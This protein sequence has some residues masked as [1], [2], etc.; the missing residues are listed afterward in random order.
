[1]EQEEKCSYCGAEQEI[2]KLEID[3]IFPRSLGGGNEIE[4]LTL[5]CRK[6]NIWKTNKLVEFFLK[7]LGITEYQKTNDEVINLLLKKRSL[8]ISK[9]KQLSVRLSDEIIDWLVEEK[10]NYPS[11]NIFFK[12]IKKRYENNTR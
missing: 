12:E 4:N 6:C 8:S 10:K 2:T 9:N 3:H 7:E 1:M 5:A 11:W